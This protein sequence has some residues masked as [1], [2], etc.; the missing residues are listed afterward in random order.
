MEQFQRV[1]PEVR[2]CFTDKNSHARD[3]AYKMTGK[4]VGKLWHDRPALAQYL[5][6]LVGLITQNIGDDARLFR[7][8]QNYVIEAT[9][10]LFRV[11]ELLREQLTP[12][13]IE[14]LVKEHKRPEEIP[15]QFDAIS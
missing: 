14:E 11:G 6:S 12:E 7:L 3:M 10:A 13:Y 2:T 15:A 8:W 5:D 4:L 1:W 9:C